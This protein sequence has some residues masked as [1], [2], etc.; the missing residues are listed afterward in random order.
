MTQ[1]NQTTILSHDDNSHKNFRFTILSILTM[2]DMVN[3]M[4]FNFQKLVV[5][6]LMEHSPDLRKTTTALHTCFRP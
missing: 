5:V 3:L 2:L 6:K 4:G 1:P